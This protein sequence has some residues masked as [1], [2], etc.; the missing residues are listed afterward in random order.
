LETNSEVQQC[1]ICGAGKFRPISIPGNAIGGA[2]FGP[3]LRE[4]GVCR[5]ACGLEFT[6][7]RPST[8]LL[9]LFYGSTIYDCHK[10]NR[11]ASADKKAQSL[12]AAI[13]RQG[14]Y[15]N[16]KRLLD[17]GC[18]GGYF[19]RH[20]ANSGWSAIGFDVGEAAIETCHTNQLQATSQFADLEPG[21]FDVILL[22][23]VLEHIEEP[24]ELLRSLRTLLGPL[25]KIFIEVPNVR[26]LRA[27]LSSP[28]LSRKCGFDE[29]HRAFPIH[30][31]YFSPHS[32]A[33]LLR[34]IGF[35]PL[36]VTTTGMGLD[37][38]IINETIQ[39]SGSSFDSQTSQ[40]DSARRR[41]SPLRWAKD[42]I[43]KIFHSF[44]LGENVLVAARSNESFQV[45]ESRPRGGDIRLESLPDTR[46]VSRISD[47]QT[48]AGQMH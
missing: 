33:T 24:E 46:E 26:S 18:G 11:S 15:S 30:L 19:L 5:C 13:T 41:N 4:F 28:I 6:N 2:I 3:Y 47:K 29:R 22:N 16:R 45:Q 40:T 32:I 31:W 20:A 35:E 38:L 48:R 42:L 43:Q 39:E 36:L 7:P 25:G 10:M 8:E 34:A 14:T 27:R 37:E 9:R 44:R 12:L 23:H 1:P 21:S 17:F